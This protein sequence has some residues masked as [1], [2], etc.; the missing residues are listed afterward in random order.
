MNNGFVTV[1]SGERRVIPEYVVALVRKGGAVLLQNNADAS[2][3]GG[4]VAHVMSGADIV[5]QQGASVYL[6]VNTSYFAGMDWYSVLNGLGV[7]DAKNF[8][9]MPEWFWN[10]ESF[11]K[12]A[13]KH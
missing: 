12:P 4:A 7:E 3:E 1:N 2:L 6:Q 5:F 8:Y 11:R 13:R 10:R 9:A